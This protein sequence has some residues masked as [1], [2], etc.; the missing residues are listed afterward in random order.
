IDRDV[1]LLMD[2]SV[3]ANY[4]PSY[5]DRLALF[6]F[7]RSQNPASK[8]KL[9]LFERL[10]EKMKLRKQSTTEPQSEETPETSKPKSRSKARKR[11]IEI[12]WIHADNKET[13]Q[14]RTKQGGGTRKLAMN[15]NAGYNEI[16]KE[17]KELF[18]PDGTSSKG[19]ECEFL[20]EVWDFRQNVLPADVSV[21]K[22]FEAVK[23]PNLRFYIA[24]RPIESAD[25]TSNTGSENNDDTSIISLHSDFSEEV[26]DVTMPTNNSPEWSVVTDLAMVPNLNITVDE[27]VFIMAEDVSDPHNISDPEITFGPNL[28]DESD[29]ENTVV[30]VPPE[31]SETGIQTKQITIRHGSC[32]HDMISEF[33]DPETLTKKLEFRRLL[34]D[35]SEEAG[36][37]AGVVRDVYSN[38]W[39]EFYDRCTLGTTMKVPFIRHDFQADTWK[40]VGRIFLKGYKDCQYIPIKLALPFMEEM[41]FGAVYSDLI[42]CFLQFVSTQEREILQHALQDFS[43]V[44]FDE[45]LEV[46]DCYEC[47]R[48]VSADNFREILKEIS[49]KELVQKPMFVLDCWKEI[50]ESQISL[51]FEELNEMYA[52]LLPTA[53]K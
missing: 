9:G 20:F 43:S 41:L 1:I 40:A 49:H 7:C 34:P 12:G 46:L 13:K 17:G 42:E 51:T 50:T 52:K 8:R 25:S 23:L 26:A 30:Y 39:Q 35:N 19:D 33:S 3:L 2:D 44:E 21:G 27:E 22:I 29:L 31:T 10:R 28:G 37:G 16:L 14:V 24:T 6:H 53:K 4:I 5:G 38:F 36:S 48:Q 45:L 15:I 32:L 47:R 18:F 11:Q